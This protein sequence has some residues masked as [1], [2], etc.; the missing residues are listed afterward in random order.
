[1][2]AVDTNILVHAHRIESPWHERAFKCLSELSRDRWAL[3]WP[4]IHE[5][6]A[7]V[8]HPR[9]FD[10]PTPMVEALKTISSLISV[11]TVFLLNET[12]GYWEV[13][14]EMLEV[15]KVVGPRIHDARIAA[16][17]RFYGIEEILTA[18]R[19]FNRFPGVKA[20]NPLLIS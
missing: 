1:M 8:T 12:N 7:I 13:L 10:P 2:I 19:D 3:P 11:P 4:C 16:L 9:V 18:D 15:S 20:S 6:L 5:F 17:C 14:T